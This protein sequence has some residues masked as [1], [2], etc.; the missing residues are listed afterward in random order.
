MEKQ[1]DLDNLTKDD[2]MEMAKYVHHVELQNQKLVEGLRETKAALMATVQQ[3]NSLNAKLQ[4]LLSEKMNT[5]DISAM[6]TEVVN[7]NIELVN[8]EQYREKK[9]F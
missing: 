9:G 2:F 3:R 5:I 6:K 4:T 8:P 1:I 7:T